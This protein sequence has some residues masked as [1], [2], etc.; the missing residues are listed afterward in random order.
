MRTL[1]ISGSVYTTWPGYV[2]LLFGL[3]VARINSGGFD[4]RGTGIAVGWVVGVGGIG[5]LVGGTGVLVGGIGVAVGGIGVE[6][7][8][9]GV[10]VG[11]GFAAVQADRMRITASTKPISQRLGGWNC[12]MFIFYFSFRKKIVARAAAARMGLH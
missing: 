1:S 12:R 4:K 6:V 9:M 11:V 2:V 3:S 7:G 8:G 10:G 5:V